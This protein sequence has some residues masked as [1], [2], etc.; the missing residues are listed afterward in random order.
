V[1]GN[2]KMESEKKTETEKETVIYVEVDSNNLIT[3]Y[4]GEN[5]DFHITPSGTLLV[6]D[7]TLLKY[8][9]SSIG[10][11]VTT[12]MNGKIAFNNSQWSVA[13]KISL[14]TSKKDGV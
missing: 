7:F 13:S 9:S 8:T 1:K 5:I 3:K 4:Y 12:C 2:K 6:L 10:E 11:K 14:Q